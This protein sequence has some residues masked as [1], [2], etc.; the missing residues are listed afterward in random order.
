MLAT[1]P[2]IWFDAGTNSVSCPLRTADRLLGSALGEAAAAADLSLGSERDDAGIDHYP[3][4]SGKK[5]VDAV[6]TAATSRPLPRLLD[7]R[8]DER[9]EFFPVNRTARARRTE[10][11]GDAHAC[12]PRTVALL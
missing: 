2:L 10:R 4:S 8:L 11:R 9:F 5:G 3:D 12:I 7:Q 1:P 6:S